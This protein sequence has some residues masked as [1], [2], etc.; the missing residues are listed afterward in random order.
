MRAISFLFHEVVP[1]VDGW[2]PVLGD[3]IISRGDP[4]PEQEDAVGSEMNHML[5]ASTYC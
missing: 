1:G 4:D 5:L 2:G 3:I